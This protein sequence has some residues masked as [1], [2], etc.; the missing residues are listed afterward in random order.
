MRRGA[1][2]L[3]LAGALAACPAPERAP[4]D[5]PPV[6]GTPAAPGAPAACPSWADLDVAALPPLPASPYTGAFDTVWRT[7]W[8]R[9]HDPTL[10][11]QDWPAARARFG[12]EVARA[13]DVDAAYTT[14]NAMLA[15]LRQSHLRAVP[16]ASAGPSWAERSAGPAIVPLEIRIVG[17]RATVTRSSRDGQHSGVPT[18]A[19][20]TAIDGEPLA[21][22]VERA[23]AAAARPAQ[24]RGDA[25]RSLAPL[26]TCPEGGHRALSYLDPGAGDRAANTD[27]RCV[28]PRATMSLGNLEHV[29]V[30][31]D[32]RMIEG[33]SV[34]YLAFN[35]WM[36]PLMAGEIRPALARL[37]AEGMQGLVLDLRQNPGGVGAMAIPM[38]RELAPA[39]IHLGSL[40]LRD[41][42]QEY[43]IEANPAAFAGPVV[44]LVDEGTASTSEIFAA[45]MQEAGR[46]RV[47]GASPSAGMALPSLVEEL[48][49]GGRLQFVVGEY[50]TPSG[51]VAEGQGVAP[52]LLVEETRAAFA[53]GRDLVL[54]AGVAS[55]RE[56]GH[57]GAP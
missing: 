20:V 43:A 26:L 19:I 31:V 17:G 52:D 30:R 48:P 49:D 47:V 39:A 2:S 33:T 11:C 53:A 57:N 10:A 40:Q 55:A 4:A 24:G 25:V 9:H 54:E 38:A 50:T 1:A 46:A 35:V 15:T 13:A 22:R 18:G 21:P 8:A 27:V 28:L 51:R 5:A 7:V 34:G 36:V 12:A 23:L 14:I 6:G 42:R 45:G 37:R 3:A 32:S 41:M 29:P 16:P 44:I 56:E